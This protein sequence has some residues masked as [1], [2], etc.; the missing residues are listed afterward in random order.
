MNNTKRESGTGLSGMMR[1][2]TK[3]VGYVRRSP[4][5]GN[6][7]V[8]LNADSVTRRDFHHVSNGGKYAK[9][10]IDGA[11]LRA[12]LDGVRAL[13][14]VLVLVRDDDEGA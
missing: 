11:K 3:L 14:P 4:R 13:A 12:V 7:V 8:E 1:T 10:R 9:L 2:H 5:T 6:A